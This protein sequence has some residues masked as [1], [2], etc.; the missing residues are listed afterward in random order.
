MIAK[1]KQ[2]HSTQR[3]ADV[4]NKH[5]LPRQ[6]AVLPRTDVPGMGWPFPVTHQQ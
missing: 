3:M 4:Q 1:Q 6:Y 5:S 2:E